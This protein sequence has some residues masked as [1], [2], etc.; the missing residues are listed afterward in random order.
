MK[1]MAL[2]SS[3]ISAFVVAEEVVASFEVPSAD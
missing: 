3:E 2:L 1:L